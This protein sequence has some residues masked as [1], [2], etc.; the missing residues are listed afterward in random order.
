VGGRR[1]HPHRPSRRRGLRRLAVRFEKDPHRGTA[2]GPRRETQ[3][4]NKL[5]D[6]VVPGVTSE[7]SRASS[8][9]RKPRRLR[10][11]LGRGAAVRDGPFRRRCARRSLRNLP[12]SRE[13]FRTERASV[14]RWLK[15]T[16]CV[17]T[18]RIPRFEC[19]QPQHNPTGGR[20]RTLPG[21]P[22]PQSD[23]SS[24]Q[25]IPPARKHRAGPPTVAPPFDREHLFIRTGGLLGRCGL[26]GGSRDG[27]EGGRG[28]F[29]ILVWRFPGGFR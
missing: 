4:R 12:G 3:T 15:D 27:G 25:A 10:P 8:R 6:L 26:S 20:D 13:K 16:D 24:A 14:R 19:R 5:E 28:F 11:D 29:S 17:W 2:H 21:T 22:P 1:R 18:T 7:T 23:S 9:S